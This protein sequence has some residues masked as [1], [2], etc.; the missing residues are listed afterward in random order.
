MKIRKVDEE[1]RLVYGEIY[2]PLVPDS[3]G[4]FMTADTIRVMAHNFLAK[5]RTNKVDENHDNVLTDCRVVESFIARKGEPDFVEGAW[6]AC[7]HVISDDLW[8]KVKRGE[9]NGFS[10][11]AYAMAR[12]RKV[13]LLVPD[14]LEGET[15]VTNGHTHPFRISFGENGLAVFGST[16]DEAQ[17]GHMHPIQN[18]S[19]TEEADGHSHRYVMVDLLDDIEVLDD[20]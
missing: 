10:L 18:G 1:L 20:E 15:L 11:E 17:A 2:S 12:K 6:V 19:V 3:Q 16:S 14:V 7:V 8:D 5:G 13:A 4:D 9:I